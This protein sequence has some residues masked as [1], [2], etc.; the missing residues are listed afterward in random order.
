MQNKKLFVGLGV[1]VLL[2]GA[3]AFIAGRMFNTAVKPVGEGGSLPGNQR[4]TFSSSNHIIPAPELPP[5]RPE[6]NGLYAEMKDNIMAVQIVS[7]GE[8][9]GGT[10]GDSS[11]DVNSAPQVDVILTSKTIIYRDTTQASAISAGNSSPMQQ[12]VEE[13]TIDF[14]SPPA[15]ISVW[16]NK[17]G[18]RIVARVL[19]YSNSLA[20]RKP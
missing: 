5:T 2:V 17:S 6:T 8:G 18:D 3:A 20:I 12:T 14:L 15:M 19:V 16:G 1:I 10:V 11:V 9:L 13:S 4:F 7:L